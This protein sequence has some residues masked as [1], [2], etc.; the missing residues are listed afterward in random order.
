MDEK[1]N[2]SDS[3]SFVNDSNQAIIK[4]IGVGGGGGNAVK[5]MYKQNIPNVNFVI[6][7]TDK[8][9]LDSSPVPHKLILGPTITRGGGAGN[10]PEVG[11]ECAEASADDIRKLFEDQT[12]MV[13]ITAGMG[14]GTGTGAGP[15]VARLAKEA[16]MLTIGI[17]TIPF[18]FEGKKKILKA[19]DGAKEMKQ[20]VDALLVINNEN[21][22]DLYKDLNF[23]NAFERADDTLTNAAR[24][25]SEIIS[26][27]LY[28][29]VDFQDVKTILK[30]SGT[31]II[32]TA[33]GEGEN[34]I[35]QAI[36]NA[37]HS[38][39]LK[40]HDIQTSKRLLFKFVCSR[41]AK[42]PIRAD[43]INEIRQ[44]T[45]NLPSSI[46]VKWG[47]GDDPSMGD[48]VKM[49]VL[50]SGFTMTL[51][52][53]KKTPGTHG[54][55]IIIESGD[56]GDS[57]KPKKTAISDESKEILTEMYGADKL[58]QQIRDMAKIKYAVLSPEQFDDH[59]V[60]AM[61]ERTPTFN[62]DPRFNEEL[63]ALSHPEPT[64]QRSSTENSDLKSS[65]NERSIENPASQN[66]KTNSGG[67][68][69]IF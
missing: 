53:E 44:F 32:S 36:H 67:A 31:A 48:A 59:D 3:S 61:L 15:V 7:N 49:T 2:I 14:G 33:I 52:D 24:S 43:E 17:V 42:N 56:I 39:L 41:D 58:A 29:N 5:N 13:F 8:K 20:H 65:G 4:V 12:E 50:A 57:N 18:L 40:T 35:S 55:P 37:L 51:F 22:L 19:I 27:D 23:F 21:L 38:P 9:A 68:P 10:K 66:N 47:I 45:D 28:I 26:E 60:I 1:Y 30:D 69:I 6:C 16:G 63:R 54:G 34:R 64:H 46:D 25:I 11:R 62:R